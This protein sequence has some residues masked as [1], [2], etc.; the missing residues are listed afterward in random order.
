MPDEPTDEQSTRLR[1]RAQSG[2]N[3][4]QE[5]STR[6]A[7]RTTSAFQ[8]RR[9]QAQAAR[10]RIEEGREQFAGALDLDAGNVEPVQL[11]DRG[12]EFGFVPDSEGRQTLA[13]RFADDRPFVDTDDAAVEAD[14]REGVQPRVD[15]ARADEVAADARQEVAAADEFTEPDDLDAEVG[16]AG[17]EG[18]ELTETGARRRS[19]RAF[20]AQTALEEVDAQSDVT[21]AD[22]GFALTDSAARRSAARGLEDEIA[23]IEQGELDPAS[24]VRDTGSGFG[25]AEQP[26]RE[27]AAD[28]IDADTP[29]VAVG[30]GDVELQETGDGGF[31]ASFEREVDR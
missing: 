30:P 4:A 10:E 15:P 12:E 14:P 24:D 7:E 17:V 11:D 5:G 31:E 8:R 23:A 19:A 9:Q 13:E 18:V 28:Q 2:L 29:D 22:D 16:A 25:L 20:E 6:L 3:R 1:D 26:A 21:A 27:V